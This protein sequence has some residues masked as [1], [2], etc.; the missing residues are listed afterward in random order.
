M[1]TPGYAPFPPPPPPPPRNKHQV[2]VRMLLKFHNSDLCPLASPPPF[3]SGQLP[4]C[5]Q[6]LHQC[7][8]VLCDAIAHVYNKQ[9]S[10]SRFLERFLG[11][12]QVINR[13]STGY[14]H[15]SDNG[16]KTCDTVTIFIT[17]IIT[18]VI[19]GSIWSKRYT[20][21]A[22]NCTFFYFLGSMPPN[23]K[24][25]LAMYGFIYYGYEATMVFSY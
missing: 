1:P 18:S 14:H 4:D 2:H 13:L 17:I 22:L 25:C 21:N 16:Q 20:P 5:Q 3:L 11:Y 8:H 10:L 24:Q 19:T 15:I 9:A 23:P 7:L 6:C 12:Q